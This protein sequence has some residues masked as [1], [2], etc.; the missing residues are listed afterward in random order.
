MLYPMDIK[1][2]GCVINSVYDYQSIN[3]NVY[4]FMPIQIF[5]ILLIEGFATISIEILII[6]VL[7]PYVGSSVIITSIIIGVF[8][9]FLSL[10]YFYGGTLKAEYNKKLSRNFLLASMFL[11]LGLSSGFISSFFWLGFTHLTQSILILLV[12][13]LLMVLAPMIFLLGQTIPITTNLFSE[14]LSVS[15]ISGYS[16]FVNTLG[17]FLGAIVTSLVLLHFLGVAKTL[18]FNT[19][20]LVF[21]AYYLFPTKRSL[22]HLITLSGVVMIIYILNIGVEHS[23]F[24]KTNN[25]GNYAVINKFDKKIFLVN[26]SLMSSLDKHFKAS[27]YIELIK[28]ILFKKLKLTHKDILV[29]GAGGFTLNAETN[30]KNKFTYLDIDDQIKTIAESYFLKRS[31]NSKFIAGDA[32]A[33]FH[34]TKSLFDVIVIDTYKHLNSIPSYLVTNDFFKEVKSHIRINGFAIFNI[35]ASPFLEDKFSKT[36]D[37]TIRHNFKNCLQIPTSINHQL[38]NLVYF[39]KK[40]KWEMVNNIYSDDLNQATLDQ[41]KVKYF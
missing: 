15:G 6:R 23:L 19:C 2:L 22:N 11:G 29:I 7:I 33:F 13:Y 20:L 4:R 14:T 27:R 1:L 37:N 38:S 25:Y 5:F 17:S 21:L 41:F 26:F 3:R 10:G 35:I 31:I 12:S 30:Y 32:R 34:S 24:V 16:L 28:S 9:L 39:C 8:L 18:F 40:S 36:V